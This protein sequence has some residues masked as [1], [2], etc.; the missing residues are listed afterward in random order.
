MTRKR[1]KVGF[2]ELS[3]VLQSPK[4]ILQLTEKRGAAHHSMDK[5]YLKLARTLVFNTLL[6]NI[7]TVESIVKER[8]CTDSSLFL[9]CPFCTENNDEC[10]H[11]PEP[12]TSFTRW[13]GALYGR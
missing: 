1:R 6:V 7:T 4:N 10:G 11:I 3:A 2:T 9:Q 8:A 13:A 12:E 5:K